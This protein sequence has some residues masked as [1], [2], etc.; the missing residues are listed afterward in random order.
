M[1]EYLLYIGILVVLAVP[2]GGYIGRVM[3]GERVFLSPFA[4]PVE[5]IFYRIVGIS[6]KEQMSWKRYAACALIFSG[7]SLA[8]LFFLLLAQ[9]YTILNPQRLG[10]LSWHL[11]F[12]TAVSFVTNTNW[13][14]YAG[15]SSLSYFS[16]V[17]G[18]TVQNFVS[19]AVGIAVLFALIRGLRQVKRATLGSFWVDITRVILYILL[20]ISIVLALLLV[21]QGVVQSV[22]PYVTVDLLEPVTLADGTVVTQQIIPR[23][24]A[25]G[26][27]AIKQLGTNGGGVMGVNSA[28]PLENATPFSNMLQMLSILLIPVAL[29]FTYGRNVKDKRQGVALFLAM[30][31]VL[32]G[33][34]A[35]IAVSEQQGTPQLAQNGAVDLSTVHQAG[36][37]MEGK[38]ARFGIAASTTWAAFTTAASNGSVNSMHDSYTPLGGMVPMLLMQL[39][40][41]V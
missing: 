1:K 38:E 7:V 19:A 26:Q 40:E 37:N 11:A 39:G 5:D 34:L 20:P 18:L 28:H 15:E 32:C 12:N 31:I 24:A 16:Q 41:V 4:E 8:V 3:D 17:L 6:K 22:D 30:L 27:V 25:A 2:L 13:Q 23:G 10:G 36:G 21:S 35:V 29:C 14:S 9:D 33:A